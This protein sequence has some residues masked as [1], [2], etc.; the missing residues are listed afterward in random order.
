M[1]SWETEGTFEMFC[2]TAK[3]SLRSAKDITFISWKTSEDVNPAGSYA[4]S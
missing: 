2:Q 1:G 4:K 3:N